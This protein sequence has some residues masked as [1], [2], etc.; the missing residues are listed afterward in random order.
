MTAAEM[1]MQ[2]GAMDFA[3]ES[4]VDAAFATAMIDHHNGAIAMAMMASRQAEHMEVERL[5]DA[6]IAAQAAEVDQLKH[7][8][9]TA[10]SSMDDMGHG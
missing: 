1:G 10:N 4:D 7:F 2:H 3:T 6:I 9:S 5:A 8:A